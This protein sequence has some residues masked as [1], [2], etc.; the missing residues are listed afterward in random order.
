MGTLNFSTPSCFVPLLSVTNVHCLCSVN[1]SFLWGADRHAPI[2]TVVAITNCS[3]HHPSLAEVMGPH[4]LFHRGSTRADNLGKPHQ[5]SFVGS[6]QRGSVSHFWVI[7]PPPRGSLWLSVE[8]TIVKST[9]E[10]R[11]KEV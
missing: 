6:G 2:M 5:I 11:K 9:Q 10:N 3:A 7:D 4:L 1:L 8:W